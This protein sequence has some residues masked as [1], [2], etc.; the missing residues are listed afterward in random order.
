MKT[1]DIPQISAK[2]RED[3]IATLGAFGMKRQTVI[4]PKSLYSRKEKHKN[5]K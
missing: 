3:R 1:T 4:K 5:I 2:I